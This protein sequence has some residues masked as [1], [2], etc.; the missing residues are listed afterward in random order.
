MDEAS[1]DEYWLSPTTKS[2][3]RVL[4]PTVE[5][6]GELLTLEF[7]NQP[8]D[9]GPPYHFHPDQEE[10]FT[11]IEGHLSLRVDGKESVL[12]PGESATVVS[13]ERHTFWNA[14]AEP[15]VF[16]DEHRPAHQFEG[17]IKSLYDLDYDGKSNAKG[18]PPVLRLMRL[19]RARLGEQ[20]LD[21]APVF[22]Q[23]VGI[24][25]LGTVGGLFGYGSTY[26][27]E[28]RTAERAGQ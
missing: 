13:F 3:L 16:T 6:D 5:T 28:R 26:V 21:S 18:S 1:E 9:I 25:V 12:G 20:W 4:V 14:T 10:T 7:E 2:R 8:G 19:F 24:F 15:V 17:F 11:V 27:S 22:L 23:R